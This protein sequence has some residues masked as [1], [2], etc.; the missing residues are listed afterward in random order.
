VDNNLKE[1]YEI[2]GEYMIQLEILQARV[3]EVKK[4]IAEGLN[5]PPEPTTEK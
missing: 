2:Y 4:K 1:L 3:M 5:K